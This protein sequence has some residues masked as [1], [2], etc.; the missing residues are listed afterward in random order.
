MRVIRLFEE[1]I[2]TVKCVAKYSVDPKEL[3]LF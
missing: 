1:G 2:K 3:Y